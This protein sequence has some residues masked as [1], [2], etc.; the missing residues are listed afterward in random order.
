VCRSLATHCDDLVCSEVPD[1][2]SHLTIH[3][4]RQGSLNEAHLLQSV[5]SQRIKIETSLESTLD[6]LTL[7][8][9]IASIIEHLFLIDP[10][11]N[12][13]ESTLVGILRMFNGS[14]GP[15][16]Q[17]L[18][19]IL[20]R[21]GADQLNIISSAE[22]WNAFRSVWSIYHTEA[23]ASS[24]DSPFALVDT[25]DTKRNVWEF[26]LESSLTGKLDELEDLRIAYRT[27]DPLFWL[28][29]IAYCLQTVT[30]PSRLTVMIENY[31]IGYALVCLSS[32]REEVRKMAGSILVRWENM[33]E[34]FHFSGNY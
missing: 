4:D 27:Y 26:Q 34:V 9:N 15:A 29:I 32:E 8:S 17:L 23:I 18:M 25:E 20:V 33:S 3:S 30:H 31:A 24:L 6:S 13:S 11:R 12:S 10:S 14:I 7:R 21:L 22:T 5:M 2:I 19:K 1:G 28:P 16:D